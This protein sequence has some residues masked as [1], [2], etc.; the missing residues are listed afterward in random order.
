[1][2]HAEDFTLAEIKKEID[3]GKQGYHFLNEMAGNAETRNL[4][5][6]EVE[7]LRH[8]LKFQLTVKDKVEL[9]TRLAVALFK[10]EDFSGTIELR[11]S[12]VPHLSSLHIE[13]QKAAIR[14]LAQS[15]IKT[16][17][18]DLALEILSNAVSQL[19]NEFE[20]Q[21]FKADIEI[22]LGNWDDALTSVLEGLR[23]EVTV[24]TDTYRACY[25][26]VTE[27]SNAG[28]IQSENEKSVTNNVY[29]RL[30]GIPTWFFIGDRGP[31]DAVKLASCFISS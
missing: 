7:C 29:V 12:I 25:L 10:L 5:D 14:V 23:K 30:S 11:S 20:F 24:S 4:W 3:F 2:D 15:A 13:N 16:H 17:K 8:M 26:L 6:I 9:N 1:M 21:F 28:L 27:L 31:I 18:N 22:K 19:P